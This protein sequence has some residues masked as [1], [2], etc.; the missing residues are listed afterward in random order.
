[1]SG[2]AHPQSPVRQQILRDDRRA[3]M[4]AFA[5]VGTLAALLVALLLALAGDDSATSGPDRATGSALQQPANPEAG[6]YASPGT[7][8]DGGPEEGTRGAGTLSQP[9]FPEAETNVSP[10]LRYDGGPEEG[11]RGAA[12]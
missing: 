2:S 6:S 12:N 11:T 10:G 3:K 7:R 1:M 5:C 8:Y 4:I 9:V